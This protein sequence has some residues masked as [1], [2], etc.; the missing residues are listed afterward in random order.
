MNFRYFF[1]SFWF[2]LFACTNAWGQQQNVASWNWY[3]SA[4]YAPNPASKVLTRSGTARVNLDIDKVH[5][6]FSESDFPEMKAT[7]TGAIVK[8][9]EIKG[10]LEGFFFHGTESREGI[11]RVVGNAKDCRRQEIILRSHVPDGSALVLARVDGK[12]RRIHNPSAPRLE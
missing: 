5:I 7:F 1:I 10:S 9:G 11:Y 8:T 2:V 6:I 12:C 4:F 3:Y